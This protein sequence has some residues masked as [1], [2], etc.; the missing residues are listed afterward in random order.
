M[1]P[2]LPVLF[3]DDDDDDDEEFDDVADR[4]PKR[5]RGKCIEGY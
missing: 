1:D 5:V 2:S 4:P 3:D